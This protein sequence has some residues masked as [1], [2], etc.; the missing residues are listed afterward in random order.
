MRSDTVSESRVGDCL[1]KAK[2]ALPFLLVIASMAQ[3]PAPVS[4]QVVVRHVTLNGTD[5]LS[6]TEQ[7][8]IVTGLENPYGIIAFG[9]IKDKVREALQDCGFYKASVSEPKVTVVSGTEL[10]GT[11]DLGFDVTVGQR[12]R[13]KNVS[14]THNQAFSAEQ[15]RALIPIADGAVFS[16]TD[17]RRGFEE[18]RKLYVSRGYIDFVPLPELVVDEPAALITMQVDLTEGVPFRIGTL[19]F[20]G[21]ES[22]PGSTAKLREGWKKYQGRIYSNDV[23]PKFV[24]ENAAYLP[25]NESDTQLFRIVVDQDAHVLHFRLDLGG[26]KPSGESR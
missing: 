15:L 16:T 17:A 22:T 23:M 8:R 3:A 1:R 26:Q 18:L 4:Q 10:N 7:Q 5:Q 9:H 6:P 24:R 13:L 25:Q 14:F 20:D 19:A 11:V 2:F 21:A 12:Y